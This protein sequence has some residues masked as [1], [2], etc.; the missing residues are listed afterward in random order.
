MSFEGCFVNIIGESRD[1][2]RDTFDYNSVIKHQIKG[3]G[4]P[5]GANDLTAIAFLD[6]KWPSGLDL[7]TP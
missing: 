5:E 4:T 6:L 3:P 7:L 2:F 1:F